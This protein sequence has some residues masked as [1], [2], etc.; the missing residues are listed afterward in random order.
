V[1]PGVLLGVAYRPWRYYRMFGSYSLA[2]PRPGSE[3]PVAVLKCG[4]Q[5]KKARGLRPG[6]VLNDQV[7]R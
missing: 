3:Y 6:L 5:Q 4:G 7:L 2:L 1:G